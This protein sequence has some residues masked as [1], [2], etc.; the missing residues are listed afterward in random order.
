MIILNIIGVVQ[1]RSCGNGG[2][3]ERGVVNMGRHIKG[4]FPI[5][6]EKLYS[7]CLV[8]SLLN[9]PKTGLNDQRLV[10]TCLKLVMKNLYFGLIW[11]S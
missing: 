3:Y 2:L 8:F 6:P 5:P 9:D 4:V 7:K 1:K 11:K 10:L